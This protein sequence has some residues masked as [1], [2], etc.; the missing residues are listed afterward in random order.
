M[1]NPHS[2]TVEEVLKSLNSSMRGLSMDEADKRLEKFGKNEIPEK[3][4]RHPIVIFLNQFNNLM[5][6]ILLVAA[7]ISLVINHLVDVF[8]ITI[9]IIINGIIGFVEEQKAE[10]AIKALKKMIVP[11]AKVYRGDLLQMD[12]RELVPGDVIL[13][14]EGD[15]VPADARLI[16]IKNF[17]TVESSL[18]GES[19]PEDKDLKV[20][21]EKVILA[22]RTNMV[23]MGTFVVGGTA[24]AIVTSTGAET[25]IGKVAQQIESIKRKKNHFEE[26]TDKLAKQTAAIACLG[27]LLA[28]LIGFFIR[29]M[30]FSEIFLFAI[31]SLVSGI[32]EGL[33]A[34]MV[35]VLAVGARRM[36]KRNAIIRMLPA[37]ETLGIVNVIATDKTGT[38]TENTMTVEKIILPGQDEI[39][40][41]GYGW[42][43][44]GNFF[45]NEKEMSPESPQ[46]S[47]LL[48]IASVCNN[49]RLMKKEADGYKII[50][51][52]TEAALVV[53]A[54]K[55]G[56]KKEELEEREKR[57]DDMPFNPELKYRASLSVLVEENKN[58]QIYVIGAPEYVLAHSKYI[59]KPVPE[60]MNQKNRKEILDHVER[61]TKKAMRVLA[62][63]YRLTDTEKLS[64]ESVKDLIF[65]G[66][67]GMMDPPRPEVKEAITKAKKAGIRVIMTT[68][69]HKGTA[70]A[71]AKEIGLTES[72]DAFTEEEL[73]EMSEN[74]FEEAIKNVSVF[75]RLTPG[76]KLRIAETLQKQG[77]VVAMTG[78][79]VN[80]APALKKA[81]IGIAMGLIGTD[82]ARESSQI[83]LA[84]DNFAT[85]V[86]AVEEGRIVFNNIRQASF[87][88][89]TTN[90]AENMTFISALIISSNF[91][92]ILLPTQLLWLNLVTDGVTGVS[93]APEQGHG[94]VLE[95]KPRKP[96]E[97]ILSK[98]IMPFLVLMVSVMVVL[99]LVVFNH[100]L[101]QGVEKAR[102]GAF[103]VMSFTQL[104]NLLNMR[105][106]TKSV[107]RIGFLNN[108]Y[109][110]GAL[111]VSTAFVFLV[112]YVPF[113]Q[114][115]FQFV[116]LGL[117]ELFAL[118]ILSSSVL[119]FGE[120]YKF[121][122]KNYFSNFL[123]NH[124][125]KVPPKNAKK[126]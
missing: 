110:L 19:S 89:V 31:A 60:R 67:V 35:I 43:P 65:V 55:A 30:K 4:R 100:F 98:D 84:D 53:L 7:L 109:S 48:H 51:D 107:F 87:F 34:V 82:V 47:K 13:L 118:I 78:D 17:R 56:L 77:N 32:P 11:H 23:W 85:I 21:N 81:D 36:A 54:E 68:G 22:D 93:L 75:A 69:D 70:V 80:D 104:F 45:Q 15:R 66:L 16:E 41:S 50:G 116:F 73:L 99:T 12:A 62:L 124:E 46:L 18:T 9:V 119:W 92:L 79:G 103:V 8:V 52:P 26:K 125:T 88:L 76:M 101:P 72:E 96:K 126:E 106:L 114:Q 20:L 105:S 27:T 121:L 90:F 2:L 97:D 64:Q 10:T 59:Y 40:V 25:A 122:Q 14:E 37:T 74:E 3:K 91:P 6:Y 86:N 44:K 94:D 115:V 42:E 95:E 29:G 83:I 117:Y 33:P 108:K 71:I 57:I 123:A 61:L 1:D 28:F 112:V 49:S 63:A 111:L 39:T 120:A 5:I 38:I 24:K 102:T 113:F 58:R